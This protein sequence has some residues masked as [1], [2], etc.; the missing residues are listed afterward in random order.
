MDSHEAAQFAPSAPTPSFP[1]FSGQSAP[2]CGFRDPIC[3]AKEERDVDGAVVVEA[4]R[5]L[6]QSKVWL[7]I[8]LSRFT[9]S[10][11]LFRKQ[12]IAAPSY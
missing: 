11:R 8:R 6:T 4:T 9:E 3:P 7:S 2:S 1:E 5:P 10:R 12:Q